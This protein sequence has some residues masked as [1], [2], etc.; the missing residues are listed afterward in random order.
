MEILGKVIKVIEPYKY[1]S[2]KDGSE[3]LR[4]GFVAET[5]EQYSKKLYMQVF[6]TE[7]WNTFSIRVGSEY[8]FRFD[9]GS[10]E[11]NGKWYTELNCFGAYAITANGQAN[12]Q[13]PTQAAPLPQPQ[14][15]PK[16]QAPTQPNMPASAPAPTSDNAD[17][18][19][20]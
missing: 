17:D 8:T 2:R 16:P 9:V 20:F 10:R 7:R 13:A 14:S 3:Q 5:K 19:P 4:Y 15:A 1:T 12:G 11:Y 6:G 18:L